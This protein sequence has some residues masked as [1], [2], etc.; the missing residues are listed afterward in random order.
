MLFSA[1]LAGMAVGCLCIAPAADQFG[2][3]RVIV[4]ALAIVSVAMIASAFATNILFLGIARLAVGMG[5]GT[6]GV[7]MTALAA[8]YAPPRHSSSAVLLVQGG[9]P[10]AAVATVFAAVSIIEN[11]SWRALLLSVGVVSVVL[12]ILVV[13]LLPDAD[14]A[15]NKRSASSDP[16]SRGQHS[17]P[18]RRVVFLW[19]SSLKCAALDRRNARIFLAIF[20]Y[21]LD[22]KVGRR[23][24]P[25]VR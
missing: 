16:V 2:R 19:Q 17:Q 25:F 21:F 3:R 22:T 4:A 5:V 24:R 1:S 20:R 14:V 13:M 23:S 10:L 8:E 9:W 7:S 11:H 6:I 12:L 15:S 18:Y